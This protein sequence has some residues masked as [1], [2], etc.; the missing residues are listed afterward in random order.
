MR[1]MIDAR[2]A[3]T[4]ASAGLLV[5]IVTVQAL[6]RDASQQVHAMAL[7]QPPAPVLALPRSPLDAIRGMGDWWAIGAR[8][9]CIACGSAIIVAAAG[10]ILGA[11]AVSALFPAPVGACLLGCGRAFFSDELA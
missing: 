5:L 2:R 8:A 11:M 6:P 4:V 9:A 10:S 1:M 3:R 7:R